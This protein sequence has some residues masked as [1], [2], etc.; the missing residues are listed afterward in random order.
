MARGF[1]AVDRGIWDHPVLRG[2]GPFSRREAWLWLISEA[3]WQPRRLVVANITINLKRG[4]LVASS[5]FLAGKWGWSEAAVRRFLAEL[6]GKNARQWGADAIADA[7]TDAMIDAQTDAG[8]TVIT[9]RNYNKYQSG[10]RLSDAASDAPTDATS[11][12]TPDAN[13]KNQK[14]KKKDEGG[15]AD[16]TRASE[17]GGPS[18]SP[19][20]GA[21]TPA[22]ASRPEGGRAKEGAAPKEYAFEHGVIHLTQKHLDQWIAAYPYLHVPGELVAIEPWA[23]KQGKSWFC[24]VASALNKRNAAAKLSTMPTPKKKLDPMDAII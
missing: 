22:Q 23:A 3:C 19:D 5:R 6:R 7:Q 8:I 2:N 17:G 13:T 14:N 10:S 9:I 1:F 4:Q 20:P 21:S 16:A 18:L 11:D 15:V 12:A 24:A